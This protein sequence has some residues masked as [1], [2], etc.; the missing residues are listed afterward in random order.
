MFSSSRNCSFSSRVIVKSVIGTKM[1]NDTKNKHA[2]NM[3]VKC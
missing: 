2:N 1:L 3:T